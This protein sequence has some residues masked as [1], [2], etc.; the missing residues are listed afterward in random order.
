MYEQSIESITKVIT[1]L[2][3]KGGKTEQS[4]DQ[5]PASADE[6]EQRIIVNTRRAGRAKQ[7]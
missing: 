3:N 1:Y 7:P 5:S 4:A 2:T 6:T